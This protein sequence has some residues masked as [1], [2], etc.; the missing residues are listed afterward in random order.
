M[1]IGFSF[2]QKGSPLFL[3]QPL[4]FCFC[5]RV[6]KCSSSVSRH[7]FFHVFLIRHPMSP[8]TVWCFSPFFNPGRPLVI[9]L[10]NTTL[11]KI[12]FFLFFKTSYYTDDDTCI[13]ISLF[14]CLLASNSVI[15][16]FLPSVIL[17]NPS[18][19]SPLSLVY[20]Q[21]NPFSII[22]VIYWMLCFND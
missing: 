7:E 19:W 5:L 20:V 16:F 10:F 2:L 3:W 17:E 14:F 8:C 4:E 1:S 21:W 22:C 9:F 11:F 6:F 12:S 15:S 18:I 13:F